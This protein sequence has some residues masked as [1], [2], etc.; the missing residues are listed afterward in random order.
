M[1]ELREITQANFDDVIA[2]AVDR[3]QSAFVS[4]VAHSLAQAWLHR[5]CAFPFA[6]YADG[7]PVGFVMLGYYESRGQ[8]TLWK[9]L[10]DKNYQGRGYGRQALQLAIKWLTDHF[11]VDE[12][13]TGVSLGNECAKHLYLSVGFQATGQ[14]EGSAEELKYI[15]TKHSV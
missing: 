9:F 14:I 5:E 13:Y 4:T 3:T 8:Y 6:I 1:V 7:T 10:I 2:L 11:A 15:C 12:V